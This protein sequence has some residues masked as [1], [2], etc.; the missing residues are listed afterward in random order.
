[1]IVVFRLLE[2][3]KKTIIFKNQLS[4]IPQ[5]K[6]SLTG[7]PTLEQQRLQEFLNSMGL[8]LSSIQG[9]STILC[10][11]NEGVEL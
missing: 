11:K 7:R 8:I 5:K 2:N 6:A 1:M 10:L 4:L 9:H 3:I